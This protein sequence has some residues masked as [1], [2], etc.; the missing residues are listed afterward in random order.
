VGRRIHR[1]ILTGRWAFSGLT[2]PILTGPVRRTPP[3]PDGEPRRRATTRYALSSRHPSGESAAT[4]AA[5]AAAASS[6]HARPQQGERVPTSF[7]PCFIPNP[8][9]ATSN[10]LLLSPLP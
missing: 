6:R 5:A 10:P 3:T 8:A 7:P 9:A 2:L 1:F 4:P